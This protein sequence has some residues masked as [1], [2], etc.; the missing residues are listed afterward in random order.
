[1]VSGRWGRS[2]IA[3][4]YNKITAT[5]NKITGGVNKIGETYNKIDLRCNKIIE[6]HRG[7]DTS[8]RAVASGAVKGRSTPEKTLMFKACLPPVTAGAA[9]WCDRG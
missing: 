2:V 4:T 8:C 9:S 5:C 1:M 7:C 6:R 3:A